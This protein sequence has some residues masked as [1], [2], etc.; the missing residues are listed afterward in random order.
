MS[1]LIIELVD[2]R[3]H[4]VWLAKASNVRLSTVKYS[5][6]RLAASSNLHINK[7]LPPLYAIPRV[8]IIFLAGVVS[9]RMEMAVS[10]F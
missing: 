1:R 10:V 4:I 2:K 9:R 6:V 8:C 3:V 5:C 7:G